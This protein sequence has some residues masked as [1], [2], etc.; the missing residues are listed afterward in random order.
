MIPHRSALES[1]VEHR[2]WVRCRRWELTRLKDWLGLANPIQVCSPCELVLRVTSW[3]H[4][5]S[6][7]I[8][9]RME[10]LYR[11][12]LRHVAHVELGRHMT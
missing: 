6:I 2:C 5:S 4:G 9:R 8:Q 12:S 3:V 11:E 7:S 10:L 1:S